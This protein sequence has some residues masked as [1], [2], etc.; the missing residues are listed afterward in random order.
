MRFPIAA[1]DQK[2]RQNESNVEGTLQKHAQKVFVNVQLG[3]L[4]NLDAVV[5]DRVT[6]RKGLQIT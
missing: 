3:H 6:S 1:F 5:V 4:G 2:W